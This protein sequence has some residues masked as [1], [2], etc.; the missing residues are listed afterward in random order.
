MVYVKVEQGGV[1]S[2]YIFKMCITGIIAKISRTYFMGFTDV[3]CIAYADDI[4]FIS[5]CKSSLSSIVQWAK[6]V[7]LILE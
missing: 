2:P 3:S 5:R 1:L 4:L 6:R 7:S